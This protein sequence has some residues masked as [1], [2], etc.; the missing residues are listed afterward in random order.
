MVVITSK[1]NAWGLE[2]SVSSTP[3]L[4]FSP[5]SKPIVSLRRH[6]SHNPGSAAKV[7]RRKNI[8]HPI[9]STTY[10]DVGEINTLP[11]AERD[12][13]NANCVAL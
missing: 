8:A 6:K 2:L 4:H 9:D 3:I 5:F 11:R 13:N 7:V 10:P 1:G 12:D